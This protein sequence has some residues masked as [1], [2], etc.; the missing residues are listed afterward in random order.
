MEGTG[1]CCSCVC[2]YVCMCVCVCR[3]CGG[4]Y[5][6]PFVC[7]LQSV[8]SDQHPACLYGDVIC[9]VCSLFLSLS[10]S[11]SLSLSHTHTHS[12]SLPPSLSSHDNWS[13]VIS[14]FT[15]NLKLTLFLLANFKF[16]SNGP[17]MSNLDWR[18][19]ATL[20]RG[21]HPNLDCQTWNLN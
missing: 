2:M 3:T 1:S 18:A 7:L 8:W 11:L 17:Y 19:L 20:T 4:K 9:S 13:A 21:C 16:T 12:L 15:W 10:C 14:Q 6:K 5:S